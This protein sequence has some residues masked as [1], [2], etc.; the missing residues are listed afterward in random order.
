MKLT[1]I[2]LLIF[3]IAL[4]IFIR[5]IN[6]AEHLNFSFDQAWGS[7][8]VLE[9]WKNKEVTLVGPGSSL[10]VRGKNLL[11]GSISYYFQLPLLL[12]GNWDPV[13]SS[14]ILMI[15]L[16]L[17]IFPL[18]YG[19]KLLAG[20]KSAFFI[21]LLYSL[22]PYFIDFTR[23]FFGPIYQL[24]LVPFIILTMGLYKKFNKWIFLFFVFILTGISLQFHYQTVI[25][26]GLLSIYY[27]FKEKNKLYLFSAIFFGLFL[28]YLPMI[29]FELKNQFYNTRILLEYLQSAK[30]SA[31]S[32]TLSPHRLLSISLMLCILLIPFY[33][34]YLTTKILVVVG[35]LLFTI[36]LLIY[37]PLP[38]HAFGMSPNWNYLM[39]KKAYEIIKKENL[40]DFNIVNLV[41][42]NLS[43]VIKYQM[44]KD[45]NF[46]N[47]EDYY[48]N[49]YLFVINKDENIFSNPAYEVNT[50]K[51]HKKLKQWSLNKA[52]YLYLF[53]RI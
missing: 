53:K 47:F 49:K 45:N 4:F 15:Y 34:K 42:D 51:P 28:G 14:Y 5:S 41:Y 39:E 33:K 18:F 30:K 6:F 24:S 25:V 36:D 11:Q 8:R 46:I 1:N 3:F 17:M 10:T 19:V 27:F 38:S 22:L 12:L 40:K 16:G 43:V 2:K 13:K 48:H 37:V 7:T 50:F 32:F 44:R 23:F 31:G 20:R 26:I 52:Y 35:L 9:I 29:V 21:V